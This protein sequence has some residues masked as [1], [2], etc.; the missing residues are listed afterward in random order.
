MN[1]RLTVHRNPDDTIPG[2]APISTFIR[3]PDEVY[4]V[5]GYLLKW[6]PLELADAI[7]DEARYW[8]TIISRADTSSLPD[9]WYVLEIYNNYFCC[10]YTSR[11]P[12]WPGDK[13]PAVKIKEI[14]FTTNSCDQGWTTDPGPFKSIYPPLH[15]HI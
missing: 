3:S 1:T 9:Y 4:T 11:L 14:H 5:R 7:M 10:V 2:P 15:T 13:Y 12:D 6:A 8:P